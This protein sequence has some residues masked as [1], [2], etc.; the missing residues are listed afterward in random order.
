MDRSPN[1]DK[2]RPKFNVNLFAW[3]IDEAMNRGLTTSLRG[4]S[5]DPDRVGRFG[6]LFPDLVAD[7]F[8]SLP[9]GE[10]G[11][12]LPEIELGLDRLAD[13]MISTGADPDSGIRAGITYLG[14]FLDHDITFDPTS[15]LDKLNDPNATTNFRT[16]GINLDS[17]YASGPSVS[18]YFFDFNGADPADAPIK[19]L[20]G[21]HAPGRDLPR[22]PRGIAVTGDPRNDEN[23][24]IA[25][26]HVGFINFHNR[27]VDHLRALGI[28][29]SLLY[30]E[31]ERLV[32]WHY[33]WI[34]VHEFLPTLVR[35]DVLA[36]VIANGPKFYTPAANAIYMPV[37]FSVAAYRMGHSMI[38]EQYRFNDNF[39]NASLMDL[40]TNTK[41]KISAEWE[42]AKWSWFFDFGGH[43]ENVAHK[44]DA[45]IT[46]TMHN[47]PGVGSVVRKNMRRGYA[48]GLPS[49]QSVAAKLGVTPLTSPEIQHEHVGDAFTMCPLLLNRTPLWFY[50]LK[51]AQVQEAGERLG[52]VGSRIVAEVLYGLLKL[53]RSSYVHAPGWTP[54]LPSATAGT[55]KMSDLLTFAGVV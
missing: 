31:A 54:S 12:L 27:V 17:L 20:V 52:Q 32:R 42:S 35:A 24:I 29:N 55:F 36:D 16:P 40:F 11:D 28:P 25:Q 44:I 18:P 15:R 5:G 49:G 10:G 51:E 3:H 30:A 23:L 46:S 13:Q 7:P 33:Q 19:L 22:N 47:I 39:P 8:N 9:V 14:Q 41:K 43:V 1:S 37:E 2:A 53:D 21:G 45:R 38:R 34:I 4:V 6:Y 50:I 48:F 26:L